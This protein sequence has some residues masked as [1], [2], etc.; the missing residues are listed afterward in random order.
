LI[1]A[2]ICDWNIAWFAEGVLTLS[3][4]NDEPCDSIHTF[5]AV[6]PELASKTRTALGVAQNVGLGVIVGVVV[7]VLEGKSI[8]QPCC[9][10]VDADDIIGTLSTS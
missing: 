9:V 7:G 2:F 3:P 1:Y 8:Q 5:N 10:A 4:L 6:L